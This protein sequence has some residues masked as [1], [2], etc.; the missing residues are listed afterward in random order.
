MQFATFIPNALYYVCTEPI[1][2]I[3]YNASKQLTVSHN[4]C[5]CMCL[6]IIYSVV[7]ILCFASILLL[8]LSA[9][10]IKAVRAE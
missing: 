7:P 9:L 3:L 5:V 10:E 2:I 8:L 4:V 6:C 1:S